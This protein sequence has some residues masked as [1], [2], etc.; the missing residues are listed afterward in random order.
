M[1]KE[2]ETVTIETDTLEDKPIPEEFKD[3]PVGYRMML[4]YQSIQN[5]TTEEKENLYGDD[6]FGGG[7]H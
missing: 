4:W 5:M 6:F 7:A 2:N 1:S 3:N